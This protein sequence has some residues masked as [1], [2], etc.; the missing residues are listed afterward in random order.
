MRKKYLEKVECEEGD[1]IKYE[2]SSYYFGNY[3]AMVQRDD[4]G[5][6]I[7][8]RDDFLRSCK[9]YDIIKKQDPNYEDLKKQIKIY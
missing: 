3:S 5:L 7:D 4:K 6:F 1:I 9:K 8:S 2:M